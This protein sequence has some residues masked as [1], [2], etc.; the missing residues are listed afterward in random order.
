MEKL[1]MLLSFILLF[2]SCASCMALPQPLPC[3]DHKFPDGKFFVACKDLTLLNSFLHWNYYPSSGTVDIAF[4]QIGESN[5]NP[6]WVAWAINPTST[7]MVGSQALVA[8]QNSDGALSAYSSPITSYDTSL[9]KG[10]LSFP[11]YD[12]S[13]LSDG[14]EIVIFATIKLPNNS[15]VVNHLW[16]QGPLLP[17]NVLGIHKL[18]GDN[19]E[20]FGSLDF[21]S[22]KIE[23]SKGGNTKKKATI[24]N[25]HGFLNAISWGILMPIGAM[26]ARHVK[27]F[28][29]ADPAWFYL[30]VTCQCVAYVV[31][32][33]GWG[34]GL[35]LGHESSGIEYKGHKCIGCTLFAL[36]TIQVL[37]GRFCRPNKQHKKRIYWEGFHY[38][39]GYGTIILGIVNIY[40]GLDILEAG[41]RAAF[42]GLLIVSSSSPWGV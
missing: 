6:R 13:A 28:K 32:V 9:Q 18:S 20:S 8:F 35:W 10:N 40:K 30:H 27:V 36:A 41:E 33:A 5:S 37:V 24:K 22:E 1:L 34:T 38:A 11:G 15:T 12:I 21:F 7:G 14:N 19:V 17:G 4:R 39:V 31:G 3:T 2:V 26:L 23:A 42:G 16:Q 25:V 29:G